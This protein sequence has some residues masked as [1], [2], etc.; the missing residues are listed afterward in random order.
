M[1][2][3]KISSR[4]RDFQFPTSIGQAFGATVIDLEGDDVTVAQALEACGLAWETRIRGICVADKMR[5]KI[6][7]Y[8]ALY[9]SDNDQPLGVVKGRYRP[10]SNLQA[11]A[12]IDGVVKD[13]KW[14]ARIQMGG[15]IYDG[16]K[17]F[18]VVSLGESEI[19]S[20]HTVHRLL[21]VMNS[22]DA[23]T[24]YTIHQFCL[25]PETMTIQSIHHPSQ[26]YK[27]RH[28]GSALSKLA[29]VD[30][31]LRGSMK[32]FEE[33]VSLAKKMAKKR[34]SS[35]QVD[36]LIYKAL[37]VSDDEIRDWV[38]GKI[39]KQPQWVNQHKI[40]LEIMS[41]GPGK[42]IAPGTVWAVYGAITDYFDHLRNVRGEE[43]KPDVILEAKFSG[44]SAKAKFLAWEICREWTIK[45]KSE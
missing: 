12:W 32:Q 43:K 3:K 22:N 4:V 8:H 23:R 27:I 24:N 26:G 30:K 36:Y 1:S 39:E 21:V 41:Q 34:I 5:T 35:D 2:K 31:L 28:T 7:G 14:T 42:D 16:V 38:E 18:L 15:M 40:I 6:P 10:V 33:F 11:F 13:P 29:D 44:Y 20:G 17:T 45:S 37:C 25:R 19:C 9:R